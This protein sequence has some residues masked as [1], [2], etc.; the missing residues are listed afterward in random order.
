MRS[1]QICLQAII[2]Y[3][4]YCTTLVS[5]SINQTHCINMFTNVL[6]LCSTWL[7][8]SIRPGL[9]IP[10][11]GPTVGGCGQASPAP[12]FS[13]LG[14][15]SVY[16]SFNPFLRCPSLLFVQ[17]AFATS[18]P[19]LTRITSPTDGWA[20]PATAANNHGNGLART[21]FTTPPSTKRSSRGQ[22]NQA[23]SRTRGKPAECATSCKRRA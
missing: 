4:K 2:I 23:G 15:T 1:R 3:C 8:A 20:R 13:G 11:Q 22:L 6:V 10:A 5:F 7:L 12:G 19:T 21:D 16:S 9:A 17:Q 14:S 18:K